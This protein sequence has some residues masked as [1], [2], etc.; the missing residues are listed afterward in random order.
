MNASTIS[1]TIT[2]KYDIIIQNVGP[3]PTGEEDLKKIFFGFFV[4]FFV[5]GLAVADPNG[6][7]YVN[8]DDVVCGSLSD[9][10]GHIKMIPVFEANIYDC[11]PGYY[12]PA[13]G[14]ECVECPINSY[15]GGGEFEYDYYIT[16]GVDN[17]PDGAYAPSGSG[18]AGACGRTLHVGNA[19][20]YLRTSKKTTPSV[21]F[22]TDHDGAADLFANMT[23]KNVPMSS[24]TNKRLSVVYRD[25]VYFLYDDTIDIEAY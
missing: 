19:W 11:D 18:D 21:Y 12:L 3:R 15:C 22:D 23:L 17:C 25:Q 6:P 10:G 2:I 16:Q 1:F 9:P 5:M 7:V 20:M 4:P 8:G 14:L 13:D 24:N